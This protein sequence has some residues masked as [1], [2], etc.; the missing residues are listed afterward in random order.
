MIIDGLL[1]RLFIANLFFSYVR[2]IMR[3]KV[4]KWRFFVSIYFYNVGCKIAAGRIK[5]IILSFIWSAKSGWNNIR[6]LEIVFKRTWLI[7]VVPP[8]WIISCSLFLILEVL[9]LNFHFITTMN[10]SYL[11]LVPVLVVENVSDCP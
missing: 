9:E 8:N 2:E 3:S 1:W 10:F 5:S 7:M 4:L 11:V 6:K